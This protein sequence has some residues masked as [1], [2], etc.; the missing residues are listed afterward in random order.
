MQ[1]CDTNSFGKL[2][3]FSNCQNIAVCYNFLWSYISS[4]Q[5]LLYGADKNASLNMDCTWCQGTQLRVSHDTDVKTSTC[6]VTPFCS[7]S[8]ENGS[9]LIW[10]AEMDSFPILRLFFLFAFYSHRNV[11]KC[12]QDVYTLQTNHEL[13]CAHEL[14]LFVSW[15]RALGVNFSQALHLPRGKPLD[16]CS[17]HSKP[18][19]L[20]MKM[21]AGL[22]MLLLPSL[23]TA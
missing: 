14:K 9:M 17:W 5:Q 21:W 4:C 12:D 18:R 3:L 23:S 8:L 20:F 22:F 6:V 7:P 13:E 2:A 11:D 19:L 1:D 15:C 10:N 16:R